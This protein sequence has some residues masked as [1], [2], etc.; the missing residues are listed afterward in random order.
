MSDIPAIAALA[1]QMREVIERIPKDQ[2]PSCM[3]CFPR[4]ACLDS[5][6]LLGAYL[7]DNGITGFKRVSGT[8]G[9]ATNNS[10]KTHAWLVRNALIVDITADQFPDGPASVIVSE[11]SVWHNSFEVDECGPSDFRE[12]STCGPDYLALLYENLKKPLCS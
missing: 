7:V 9:T 3:S 12:T 8:R 11:S 2:L 4:G 5:S 10:Q 1:R 6:L